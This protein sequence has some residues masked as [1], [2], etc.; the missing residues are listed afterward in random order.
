MK[1]THYKR[2]KQQKQR[3]ELPQ[4]LYV[5]RHAEVIMVDID[6]PY[7]S[8]RHLGQQR[9]AINMKE[10]P[11]EYYFRKGWIGAE[12]H[13]A[14]EKFRRLYETAGGS[15]VKAMDY[16]KEPVDGGNV[17]D[18]LT[19]LKIRSA[20]ELARAHDVLGQQGYRLV[21]S[22]SGHGS[23]IKDITNSK[24]E[25][26]VTM[27]NYKRCMEALAVFWGLKTGKHNMM[28]VRTCQTA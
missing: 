11:N 16:T 13:K 4:T 9:V 19:D 28:P 26:E 6:S 24:W 7:E 14:G 27:R 22:V 25:S 1:S 5:S 3:R 17:S 10:S 18:G 20:K 15:G 23:W 2:K 12:Q 8:T 21:E